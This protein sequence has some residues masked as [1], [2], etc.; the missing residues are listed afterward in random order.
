LKKAL[1]LAIL[2]AAAAGCAGPET[3]STTIAEAAP[4]AAAPAAHCVP[5]PSELVTK[6]EE[7]GK[8]DAVRFR[9]AVLVNYTGW[10]YDGCKPDFKGEMFDTS[11]GKL[12]FSVMVGAGRVIRGWDE[13]LLGMKE[14]GK[15]LLVIPAHKAYG[16]NPPPGSRIPPNSA[17][18]FEVRLEHIIM[19]PPK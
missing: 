16:P 3:K 13:G 7:P 19:Q 17:L 11:E 4:A 15:R 9:S 8:G 12:P 6:D 10:V 2:A 1:V 14:G 18:V 5:P